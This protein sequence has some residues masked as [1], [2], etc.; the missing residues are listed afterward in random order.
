MAPGWTGP[1]GKCP[2]RHITSQWMGQYDLG[3]FSP[4][5]GTYPG[6]QGSKNGYFMAKS[7]PKWQGWLQAKPAHL[8]SVWCAI[9]HPNGCESMT[10]GHF[11]HFQAPIQGSRGPKMAIIWL[12]PGPNDGSGSRLDRPTRK[13]SG[14]PYHTPIHGRASLGAIFTTS[15]H[16]SRGPGVQKWLFYG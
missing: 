14:A 3:P 15:R 7:R 4:L 11:R 8:E 6:F 2:V 12:N 9:S 5:P 1:P 10:W 13:A 16:L